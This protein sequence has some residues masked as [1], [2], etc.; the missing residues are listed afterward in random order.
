MSI[1]A[2]GVLHAPDESGRHIHSSKVVGDE[3]ELRE[4]HKR[5]T[6]YIDSF[7]LNL[8]QFHVTNHQ[9]QG[10]NPV[11]NQLTELATQQT[12]KMGL[13]PEMADHVSKFVKENPQ[14]ALE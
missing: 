7:W 6:N 10:M 14:I 1:L 8:R 2:S 13:P 9:V 3:M 12:S 4:D 11:V 5:Y